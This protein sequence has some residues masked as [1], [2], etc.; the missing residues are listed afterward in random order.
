MLLVAGVAGSARAEP[1]LQL[2]HEPP[3]RHLRMRPRTAAAPAPTAPAPRAAPPTPPAPP[4]LS[5]IDPAGDELAALRD[6][7]EPVSFSLTIGYQVDGARPS[8]KGSLDLPVQVGRDYDA[9]RSYG[10][11]ELF[12]STRGVALD[13]LSSYFSLRLDAAQRGTFHPPEPEP[14][15][16]IAPPIATWFER[17]TFEVRTGWGEMKDFLPRS[18]G[19]RKLRLRAGS[20]YVYGPW[21]LHIDGALVAYDGDI[22]TATAYG[23]GRHADYTVDL[24]NERYVVGG[25]SARIDLR[26]LVALP[27]ALTG[28]TLQVQSFVAGQPDSAHRQ[29]EIDWQPRRDFTLF[30]QVRTLDDHI[31]NERMQL[32]V[33]YR[34]VTNIVVDVMRRLDNDWRWDPSLIAADD[35]TA[36]R[37]YLDLG[38]V[39][40]QI[41]ASLRGGTLIA[42][43]VD[44]FARTTVAADL[45]KT[46]DAKSSFSAA[47]FEAGG[48]LELRLRRQI[49]VGASVLSRQTRR[50]DVA[51]GSIIDVPGT[52]DPL[53]VSSTTGEQGFTEIGGRVRM[54]L[55]ARRFSTMLEVYGRRTTYAETYRSVT[56]P[57]DIRDVRGGGRVTVD[58]W[59][60]KRLRLFASYDLSSAIEFS[61]DITSYKSLRLTMT[62][63]Y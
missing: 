33:R 8:G 24:A 62:G 39:L 6:V 2:T 28:E 54:S 26:P 12:F 20:Q 38:P 41:I 3:P 31:A 46:D 4:Q 58:A 7:R 32:R 13:S 44:L 42:E 21:V 59:I 52:P 17:N 43:N 45:T 35:P 61:P 10:F 5:Q 50:D 27:I 25:A 11:G 48:A 14:P 23:G 56:E 40:P 30:A 22:V 49:A 63:V 9:L 60:G 47:Y 18:W 51:L 15:G 34:D 53:P 57:I 1:Q 29:V 36:A 19:L 55:G 16:R 37:R